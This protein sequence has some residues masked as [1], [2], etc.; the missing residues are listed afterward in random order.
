MTTPTTRP[1]RYKACASQAFRAEFGVCRGEAITRFDDLNLGDIYLVKGD[2]TW[3]DV[4][5]TDDEET[6]FTLD[7]AANLP[8]EELV[9][10]ARLIFMT[11]TGRRA[12]V[13]A[14]LSQ[15]QMY[16][17]ADAPLQMGSEYVLIAIEKRDVRFAPVVVPTPKP[18]AQIAS[19]NVVPFQAAAGAS[20]R[21]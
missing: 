1:A 6:S 9:T 4:C 12:D 14:T 20:R 17:V 16:L 19:D 8:T 21:G 10:Y 11:T 13:F 2:A 15:G 5:V 3:L 18:A 7:L